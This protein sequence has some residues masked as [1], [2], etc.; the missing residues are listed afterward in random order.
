MSFQTGLINKLTASVSGQPKSWQYI[1]PGADYTRKGAAAE[2]DRRTYAATRDQADPHKPART[3]ITRPIVVGRPGEDPIQLSEQDIAAVD[4]VAASVAARIL[5]RIG[6][7]D[8][9]VANE[10][11]RAVQDNLA[12]ANQLSGVHPNVVQFDRQF[13]GQQI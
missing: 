13:A 5:A 7:Q 10:I 4:A 6:G 2:Q 11:A 12:S 3:S 9:L 1:P 8:T